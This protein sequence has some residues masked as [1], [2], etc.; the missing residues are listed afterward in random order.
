MTDTTY[1][2]W[3]FRHRDGRSTTVRSQTWF[4]AR[5]AACAELLCEPGEIEGELAAETATEPVDKFTGEK[6]RSY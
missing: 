1:P 2:L 4:L 5:H 3:L 6:P